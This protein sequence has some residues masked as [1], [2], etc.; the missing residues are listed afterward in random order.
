[1]YM[2]EKKSWVRKILQFHICPGIGLRR[3]NI[4]EQVH[5][6]TIVITSI[7]TVLL[8]PSL[9]MFVLPEAE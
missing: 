8:I 9:K 5:I 1:M 3:F 2:A 7:R 6:R 4:D